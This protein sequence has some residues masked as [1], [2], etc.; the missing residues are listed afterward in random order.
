MKKISNGM[1][2]WKKRILQKKD[3]GRQESGKSKGLVPDSIARYMCRSNRSYKHKL[4]SVVMSKLG[5][6]KRKS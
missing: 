1:G 2:T 5:Q 4:Y 6:R 3:K